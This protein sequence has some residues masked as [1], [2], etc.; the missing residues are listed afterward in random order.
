LR[1]LAA[2]VLWSEIR[3]GPGEL[4]RVYWDGRATQPGFL[5]DYAFLGLGLV[6]LFDATAGRRRLARARELADALWERF[7]DPGG[8]LFMGQAGADTPPMAR[9]RDRPV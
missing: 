2:E 1:R 7:A 3:T 5:Q 4:K 6:A 8:R 9:A